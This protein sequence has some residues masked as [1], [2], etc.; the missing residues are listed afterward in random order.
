MVGQDKV[1][2]GGGER[3]EGREEGRR[4]EERE[5]RERREEGRER[6]GERGGEGGG[7]KRAEKREK[8]SGDTVNFHVREKGVG[9][10]SCSIFA[11]RVHKNRRL[12]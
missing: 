2:G 9:V 1:W 7:G 11:P 10:K 4:E 12:D 6:R 5:R 3:E 8:V